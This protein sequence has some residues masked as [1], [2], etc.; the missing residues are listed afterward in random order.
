MYI[1]IHV[2]YMYVV[3]MIYV[4]CICIIGPIVGYWVGL[5]SMPSVNVTELKQRIHTVWVLFQFPYIPVVPNY[6]YSDRFLTW[7]RL[8]IAFSSW[9]ELRTSTTEHWFLFC[10]SNGT[11]YEERITSLMMTRHDVVEMLNH[12]SGKI[13]C[14]AF[15]FF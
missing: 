9:C 10:W 11:C 14:K 8:C 6:F 15:Y 13:S 4:L 12:K 7:N 1:Y 5:R 3:Y 2:S